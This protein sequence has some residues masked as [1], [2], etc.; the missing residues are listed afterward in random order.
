[1][2]PFEGKL[3]SH[4]VVTERRGNVNGLRKILHPQGWPSA[5]QLP[6]V[7]NEERISPGTARPAPPAEGA[8]TADMVAPEI[9]ATADAIPT[10]HAP[11]TGLR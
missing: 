5:H 7:E 11:G 8:R 4:V 6:H 10:V 1:M 2:A 9:G 3:A